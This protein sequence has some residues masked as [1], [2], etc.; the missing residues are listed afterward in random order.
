MA[1]QLEASGDYRVVRKLAARLPCPPGGRLGLVVDVETTGM[2]V[3]GDEVI[4]LAM[5]RSYSPEGEVLGVLDAGIRGVAVA[6]SLSGLPFRCL[7]PAHAYLD[8]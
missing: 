8:G 7:E 5:V 4:E 2:D 3:R 6:R 1:D